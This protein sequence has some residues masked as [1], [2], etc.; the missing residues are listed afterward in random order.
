MAIAN[1]T[2]LNTTTAADNSAVSTSGSVSPS[3]NAL[4]I[5][6]T[7]R[8]AAGAAATTPISIS[9]TFSPNLT[10]TKRAETERSTATRNA[11][12]AI[13]TAL[14][15]SSPGSGTVTTTGAAISNRRV[16]HIIQVATGYNTS[17][18]IKQAKAAVDADADP[19]VLTLDS[20]PDSDSLVLAG[21]SSRNT[22][23]LAKDAAYTE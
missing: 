9:D 12:A 17:T 4:L 22:I 18:P 6:I 21:F 8:V 20:S 19:F 23:T 16:L 14:S 3:A 11:S 13:W 7:L 5:V 1:P 10:W 15:G 2:I